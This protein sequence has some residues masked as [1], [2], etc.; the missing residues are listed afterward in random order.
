[1]E[2]GH[3]KKRLTKEHIIH[4]TPPSLPLPTP[5]RGR[6]QTWNGKHGV[7]DFGF[8]TPNLG[9]AIGGSDGV[10]L[11]IRGVVAADCDHANR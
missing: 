9:V 6:G 2:K 5:S 10:F 11:P 7:N 3:K 4:P 8:L 1:M